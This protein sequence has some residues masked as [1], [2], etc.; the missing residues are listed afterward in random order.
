MVW[1]H[2][3][4]HPLGC[5]LEI[6]EGSHDLETMLL[7]KEKETTPP[8]IYGGLFREHIQSMHVH[9]NNSIVRAISKRSLVGRSL[10]DLKWCHVERCPRLQALYTCGE[11]YLPSLRK[12]SACDLPMAYC[13]FEG[14]GLPTLKRYNTYTYTI[15]PDLCLSSYPFPP[16]PCQAWRPSR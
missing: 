16:S 1:D 4:L 6:G 11:H 3:R 14:R 9:D 8:D 2:Q 7:S 15:A 10:I 13:I 5:H 12:L